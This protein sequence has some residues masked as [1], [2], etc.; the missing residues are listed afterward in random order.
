MALRHIATGL[1]GL[2]DLEGH[3]L[4]SFPV[5][6]NLNTLGEFK[7]IRQHRLLS[8]RAYRHAIHA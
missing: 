7:K 4:F 6:H 8:P 5:V 1:N 3:A 2:E